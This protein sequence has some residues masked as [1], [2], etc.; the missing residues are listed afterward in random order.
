MPTSVKRFEWCWVISLAALVLLTACSNPTTNERF[1]LTR[2]EANWSN[3]QV[4]VSCEQRLV[5]SQEARE[6]L[7]HGVPLTIDLELSLRD[8]ASQIRAVEQTNSY[9]I[10]Y[11]PLSDHYQLTHAESNTV[12]TFPRL[13][14]IL[15]D[16]SKLQVSFQTGVLPSGD[17]E[18]LARTRL[19]RNSMPPP[20]RL[21]VLL[22]ASWRH[23]TSWSSWPLVVEP[24]T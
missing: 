11:L 7:I 13:R 24:G 22:S 9:E 18:L 1:E 8:T 12:K 17:Y 16:L 3:G 14:H 15:A 10:R 20:M 5:L 4:D 2:I 23:D 19:D 6:A 21:P